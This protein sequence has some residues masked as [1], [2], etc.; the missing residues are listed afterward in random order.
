MSND[1]ARLHRRGA[2]SS[3]SETSLL[4]AI[5]VKVSSVGARIFRNNQGVAVFPDGSRVRYGIA[6][7]GGSDLIGWTPIKITPEMVGRTV[8]VFTAIEVKVP[9]AAVP[10]HQRH[11][12]EVVL[13]AGGRAGIVR[14]IEDAVAL[15]GEPT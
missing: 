4:R 5:M 6:N 14:S 9:G 8:A 10:D 13:A 2:A 7:P 3:A 12:V 1:G 11:F 15:V